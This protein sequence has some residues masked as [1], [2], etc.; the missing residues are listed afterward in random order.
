MEYNLE[1]RFL[2]VDDMEPMRLMI[3]Q[4]LRAMG[5]NHIKEAVDG[6][7]AW[8]A[9]ERAAAEKKPIDFIICDWHMPE[10]KGIDLLKRCRAHLLYK[11][12][13]FVIVTSSAEM[14]YVTEAVEAGVDGYMVKPFSPATFTSKFNF[15]YNK[16]FVKK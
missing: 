1:M 12:I 16:R 13:A 10:L 11:N 14:Q 7:A 6:E 8:G 4:Q 2:V 9:L 15:T 5:F 3:T